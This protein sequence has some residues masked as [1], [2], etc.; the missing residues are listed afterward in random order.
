L[1]KSEEAGLVHCSLN[2]Q[3]IDF[4]CNCCKCHCIIL[5]TALSQSKP[6]L[7]LNSG[8]HPTWNPDLCEACETC[9]E[10]CPTTALT[11]GGDNI[12]VVNLDLCIGCGVCATGCPEEA[13]DLVEREGILV[14]P[15]DQKALAEAVKEAEQAG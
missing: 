8:F 14:P 9:I 4:L 6:G 1:K 7:I 15:V 2:R 12:P 11:V 13:I 5:D 10:N 3:E